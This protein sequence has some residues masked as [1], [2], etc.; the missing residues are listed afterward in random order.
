MRTKT[1]PDILLSPVYPMEG[2]AMREGVRWTAV[3]TKPRCEKAVARYCTGFKI[4]NYLPLRR[5]VERYQRRTVTTWLPM[6]PGYVFVQHD[7]T[8]SNQD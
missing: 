3:M 8:R 5:R 1:A 4:T 2:I 6:F 7:P